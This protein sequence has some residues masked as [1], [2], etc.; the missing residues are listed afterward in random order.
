M[1]ACNAQAEVVQGVGLLLD[2]GM[3]MCE[4]AYITGHAKQAALTASRD[5]GRDMLRL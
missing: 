1:H 2:A 3:F 5:S 4:H